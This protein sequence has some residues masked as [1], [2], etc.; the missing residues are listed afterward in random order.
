[1][2]ERAQV[3]VVGGGVSGLVAAWHLAKAGARVVL[4]EADEAL[5]GKLRT[6]SLEGH[7]LDLGPDAFLTR[8]PSAKVLCEELGLADDLVAPAAS[9]A[10]IYVRGR[11]RPLPAGLALGVPTDLVGLARSGIVAPMAVLRAA[12]DLVL[13]GKAAPADLLER[14]DA[15][16]PDPTIARVVGR[17]LGEDVLWA[18]AAPLLGGINAGDPRQLSFASTAPGLAALAAGKRSLLLAC[19]TAAASAPSAGS[20][21]TPVFLGLRNGLGSLTDALS[22]ACAKAGV[23]LRTNEAVEA[24][25]REARTWR[26]ETPHSVVEAD[27]V[28]LAVP[29]PVAGR[30]L[31]AACPEA[32]GALEA[33]PYASVATITLAWPRSAVPD[34]L[35]RELRGLEAT[36][37]STDADLAERSDLAPG[38]GFL[39]PHPKG[40]LGG[41]VTAVTFTSTKW[42]HAVP[43][44]LVAL[45]AFVGRHGDERHRHLED[46]ALIAAVAGE[47]E[48]MTG[49]AA[50]PTASVLQRWPRSFPQYTSGHQARIARARAALRTKALQIALAGA[51]Y[52]GIGIPACVDSGAAAALELGDALG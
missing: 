40:A 26:A 27:G 20:S 33:V 29:A 34:R 41:L 7:P 23:E 16:G 18:L 22:A 50:A 1:M 47:I 51:A 38:S 19:R 49:I 46:Q 35:R 17:R 4:F 3:V 12:A 44:E 5:G 45:R 14:L 43:R 52:D 11:L 32:A 6:T 13:P 10:G 30:L 37:R 42:P 25:A 28:V 9:G 15:G 24:L 39:V 48:A 36:T 21:S 31:E 2:T 8:R